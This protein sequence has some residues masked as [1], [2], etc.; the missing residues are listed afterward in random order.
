MRFCV[1]MTFDFPL[2]YTLTRMIYRWLMTTFWR[3][4]QSCSMK[5]RIFCWL[6]SPLLELEVYVI[7]LSQLVPPTAFLLPFFRSSV[8]H[9]TD[10]DDISLNAYLLIETCTLSLNAYQFI[11]LS[12]WWSGA[13]LVCFCSLLC[14]ATQWEWW[15]QRKE[16]HFMPDSASCKAQV[17]FF[18]LELV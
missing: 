12:A 9:C 6:I 14:K 1:Q 3:E 16:S 13:V 8:F 5:A 2:P 10:C 15:P 18:S 11:R 4:R 17:F 7:S